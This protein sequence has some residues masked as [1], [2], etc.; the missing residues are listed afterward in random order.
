MSTDGLLFEILRLTFV[1]PKACLFVR[2]L[3][4]TRFLFFF[5]SSKFQ[6]QNNMSFLTFFFFCLLPFL[7]LFMVLS[8]NLM[9]IN[10]QKIRKFENDNRLYQAAIKHNHLKNESCEIVEKIYV[11][12][13]AFQFG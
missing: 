9:P 10:F 5:I 3:F 8:F 13:R 11:N 6:V 1:I 12:S 7:K 2:S 4:S